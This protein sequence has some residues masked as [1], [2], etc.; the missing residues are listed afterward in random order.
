MIGHI[1]TALDDKT[2][3]IPNNDTSQFYLNIRDPA[4]TDGLVSQIQYC[5]AI[6][7]ESVKLYYAT[8]GFYQERDGNY[9][10][11][12]SFDIII[13]RT[14]ADSAGKI[15]CEDMTTPEVVVKRGETI[16]ICFR[17]YS[18]SFGVF[19]SETSDTVFE[20]ARD[21]LCSVQGI[22]PASFTSNEIT[23]VFSYYLLISANI[24]SGQGI[25]HAS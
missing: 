21:D 1:G 14:F 24:L 18:D 22:I 12:S 15:V 20:V 4:N 25:L 7:S 19:I 3:L 13:N 2:A 16:G 10:L 23:D 5:Y 8:V 6:K 11:S 9:T 17:S